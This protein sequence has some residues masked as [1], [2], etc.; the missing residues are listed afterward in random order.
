[1]QLGR[2]MLCAA[3]SASLALVGQA[4]VV[5]AQG[6]ITGRVTQEG[7]QP[8]SDARVLAIGTSLTT[9]TNDSGKFTIKNA[10]VGT[11]QLQVLRVGFQS[12]RGS[13]SV[14]SGQTANLDF[15]LKIA[16]AQLDEIV[17]TATGQQRRVELGNAL[18]TLGDV[19]T[20]VEQGQ[21]RD[22]GQM[23]VAKAP[24]VVVLPSNMTG[25]APTVR[26]RGLSSISL[27]NA[28]IWIV[29]GI[30]FDA[31]TSSLNAQ[32]S[33]SMLNSLNPDEIEDI[34]IVKGPSAA[35]LYGTNASNGVVVVTTRK[36]RAGAAKWTFIGERGVVQDR[37]DYQTMY[38]NWGHRPT[39]A[40]TPVRCKL[41]TMV[42]S[43]NPGGDCI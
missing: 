13:V 41:P 8:V 32:T 15:V 5:E 43:K 4:R 35:T 21:I 30:R 20:R 19:T 36:G 17:T 39:G 3:V 9:T 25:G 12:Q 34:E 7:G 16:V 1:M 2:W 6:T 29:D 23:L 31:G 18:A 24:G 40:T 27:T 33:F 37:N 14:T 10:P 22:M 42:T 38:A 28:P 11:T 26:I